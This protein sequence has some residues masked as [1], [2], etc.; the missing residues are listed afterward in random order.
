MLYVPTHGRAE[1]RA[2]PLTWMPRMVAVS[3]LGVLMIAIAYAMGRSSET[4]DSVPLL[5]I[6]QLTLFVPVLIR[7]LQRDCSA[8]EAF[9]GATALTIGSYLVKVCYSPVMFRFPDELQH[10]RTLEDILATGGVGTRNPAL[11]I[12][13]SYPG[14]ELVTSSVVQLTSLP[15]FPAALVL[16]GVSHLALGWALFHL[17]RSL[18]GSARVA[19][20]AVLVYATQPHYQHFDSMFIYQ[21]LGLTFCALALWCL[22]RANDADSGRPRLWLLLAV[23]F[24]AAVVP[25]HHISTYMLLG[26]LLLALLVQLV[27]R[28]GRVAKQTLLVLVSTALA[29]GTWIMLVGTTT[30]T[31]FEPAAQQLADSVLG[32]V[33]PG[34]PGRAAPPPQIGSMLD[35]YLSYAGVVLTALGV[36]WGIL[37]LR[38]TER[39]RPWVF[40]MVIAALSFFFAVGVRVVASDGAELY[41]RAV[42]FIFIPVAFVIAVVLRRML[43]WRATGMIAAGAALTV[44]WL[45]GLSSG[46]PPSW[47]RVPTGYLPGAYESSIDSVGIDASTWVGERLPHYGWYWATDLF[48][49]NLVASIGRQIP[50]RTVSELFQAPT[51]TKADRRFMNKRDI[52]YILSDL[53]LTRDLPAAGSYFPADPNAFRYT[54]PMTAAQLRK[55]DRIPSASRVYD[56]GSI[57]IYDVQEASRV[58]D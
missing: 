34:Q 53:R 36:G 50:T 29:T 46:W 54:T 21:A 52:R 13:P 24:A 47:Q 15:L 23:L 25:T 22:I 5:W 12:S 44:V 56:N 37:Q 2:V 58:L 17:V 19:G 16:V 45:G 39:S 8:R 31:Y 14:L 7:L 6:G 35:R 38:R 18:G 42:S 48:N 26:L 10:Q 55:F 27:L 33:N 3:W 43:R 20:L 11:P 1:T 51:V 4:L 57:A 40:V 30:A 32:L 9:F 49:T 41:G 28:Q